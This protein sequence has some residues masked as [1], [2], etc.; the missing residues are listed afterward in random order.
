MHQLN[1][2]TRAIYSAIIYILSHSISQQVESGKYRLIDSTVYRDIATS[3]RIAGALLAVFQFS[4][5]D[6]CQSINVICGVVSPY[7]FYRRPS[8]LLRFCYNHSNVI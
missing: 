7:N 3:G 8:L 2:R 5:P 1:F 4:T 6:P